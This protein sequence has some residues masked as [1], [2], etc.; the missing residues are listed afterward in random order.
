MALATMSFR[1]PKKQRD[2][3]AHELTDLQLAVGEK[4]RE[5]RR[6]EAAISKKEASMH[7]LIKLEVG[8]SSSDVGMPSPSGSSNGC[9]GSDSEADDKPEAPPSSTSAPEAA[10][11]SASAPAP[12]QAAVSIAGGVK[13]A[14]C[15][16]DWCPRCW[17]SQFRKNVRDSRS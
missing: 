7:S 5:L 3:T 9:S 1:D 10:P 8:S 13:V 2:K 6:L 4:K 15:P 16:S 14:S 11:S 17:Y 12:Q